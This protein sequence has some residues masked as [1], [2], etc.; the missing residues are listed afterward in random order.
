MIDILTVQ[1]VHVYI[2]VPNV[3]KVYMYKFHHA[4]PPIAI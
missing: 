2:F 3:R 1:T 4:L